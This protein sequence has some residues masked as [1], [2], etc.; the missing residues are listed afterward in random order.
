METKES[1]K[2]VLQAFTQIFSLLANN[3]EF[4]D[5]GPG[6]RLLVENGFGVAALK[7]GWTRRQEQIGLD[8]SSEPGNFVECI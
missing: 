2:G 3:A 6:Q 7:C 1:A 5:T 8:A 4:A